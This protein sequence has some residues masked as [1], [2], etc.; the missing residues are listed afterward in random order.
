[1][2]IVD[3]YSSRQKQANDV[4]VYDRIPDVL[5]MQVSNI[6]ER[7]LGPA[8]AEDYY[9]YSSRP[10]YAAIQDAVAHEHGRARLSPQEFDPSPQAQVLGCIRSEQQLPVWL[11]LVEVALRVI[12]KNL[13]GLDH[14]DRQVNGIKIAPKDAVS[15]LNERF[16]RA[17]FGYRYDGGQ[18]FRIDSELLHQEVTRPALLL[19]SDPRFAGADQEFRAAHKHFKAGEFKDCA[20]DALNALE[21][22]MKTICDGKGWKYERGA[23]ASDLI[24][25]LKNNGL[26]PD[27]ADMSFDQLIATLK[28]GLPVVRNTTGGHGQGA[29]PI[30]VPEYVAAYALNLSASKIR[31]LCDAFRDS[32]K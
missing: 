6:V 23:R 25:I 11:D 24:K 32:E 19:L 8:R 20:V 9:D 21:S 12:E 2:P 18:I 27:F 15:E 10:L 17:G 31:L 4:W 30:D 14:H 13:G 29:T 16:R 3:M 7:A 22:T 28:S 26:F 5:R 1:M